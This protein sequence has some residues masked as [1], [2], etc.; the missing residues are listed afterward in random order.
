MSTYQK[1]NNE[2]ELVKLK[3]KDGEVKYLNIKLKNVIMSVY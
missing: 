3:T 1:L 2:P